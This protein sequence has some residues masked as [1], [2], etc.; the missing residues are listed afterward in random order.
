MSR[1][2]FGARILMCMYVCFLLLSFD[3]LALDENIPV[4]DKSSKQLLI[5]NQ[6]YLILFVLTP[7]YY[8]I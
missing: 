3:V 4:I 8:R 6:L 5:N 1:C 7:R 2:G